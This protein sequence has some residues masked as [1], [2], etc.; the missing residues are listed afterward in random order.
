MFISE[1]A[2]DI[3]EGPTDWKAG[4]ADAR[5]TIEKPEARIA[6]DWNRPAKAR[7]PGGREEVTSKPMSRMMNNDHSTALRRP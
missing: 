7:V 1:S 3:K 2:T 4:A 6:N 5:D